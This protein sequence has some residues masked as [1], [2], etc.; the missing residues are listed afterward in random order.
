MVG[1]VVKFGSIW[2][3]LAILSYLLLFRA[4]DHLAQAQISCFAFPI[5]QA[6]CMMG[7]ACYSFFSLREHFSV[8]VRCGLACGLCGIVLMTMR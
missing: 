6:T 2:A 5:G 4:L 7:F 3:V 1:A 8:P